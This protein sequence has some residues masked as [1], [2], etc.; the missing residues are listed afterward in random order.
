[1]KSYIKIEG[2][3]VKEGVK[4]LEKLAFNMPKICIM[5]TYIQ[6]AK[7]LL[8][9]MTGAL[10]YFGVEGEEA[11]RRCATIVSKSG[12]KLDGYDFVYEWFTKPKKEEL[13]MLRKRVDEALT[14]LGL[15]YTIKSK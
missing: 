10:E 6:S 4:A 9:T 2:E 1:M 13:D 14:P 8:N 5:N 3:A 11:E 7:P 15:K 12:V